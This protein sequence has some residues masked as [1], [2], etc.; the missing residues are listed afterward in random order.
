MLYCIRHGLAQHNLNYYKYGVQTF[1]HKMYKDTHL[2]S[3]GIQQAKTLRNNW[4]YK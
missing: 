1:Y 2:V 4:S 3:Q